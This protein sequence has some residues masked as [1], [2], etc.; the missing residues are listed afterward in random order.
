MR[1]ALAPAPPGA[2][3]QKGWRCGGLGR[4]IVLGDAEGTLLSPARVAG[5]ARPRVATRAHAA[6]RRA[7]MRLS[8]SLPCPGSSP[9]AQSSLLIRSWK[10]VLTLCK[11]PAPALWAPVE[12]LKRRVGKSTSCL[13]TE[14]GT[15]PCHLPAATARQPWEHWNGVEFGGNPRS[16]AANRR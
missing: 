4:G 3:R 8:G 11:V 16:V 9:P 10:W 2:G 6:A 5:G 12:L 15:S 13:F 7:R 14:D 1:S